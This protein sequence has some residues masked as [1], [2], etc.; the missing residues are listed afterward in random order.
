MTDSHDIPIID[1]HQHFWDLDNHKYPWL[2]PGTPS[3]VGDTT[4]IRAN[5]LPADYAAEAWPYRIVGTVH[6][7]G[8]FDPSDAFG[9][10]RLAQRLHEEAGTPNAVVAGVRLDDPRIEEVLDAHKSASSLLRGVRHIV[11]WH[12]IARLSYVDRDDLMSD[13]AWLYGYGRAAQ[14]GLSVDMQIY[15]SQMAQA[16]EIAASHAGTAMVVN[17]AGMPDGL[18]TGDHAFWKEGIRRLARVPNVAIKISGFGMLKADWN[19][20]DIRPLV[21]HIV[22]EFGPQRV[23]LGSNFPVDKLFMPLSRLFSAYL[24]S[25]DFLSDSDRRDVAARNA[26]RVYRM[27]I[28]P[29]LISAGS[30]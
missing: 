4:A 14:H 6:L 19:M 22:E 8:G 16:A 15:P 10:T 5:F 21:R 7:D 30:K 20:D 3:I 12:E 29:S 1:A 24:E 27:G 25:L 11:A 13:A 26:I 28:D 23:M 9:E 18:V 2:A 17:Q